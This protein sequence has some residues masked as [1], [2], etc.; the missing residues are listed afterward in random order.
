MTL[1]YTGKVK[2]TRH[3]PVKHSFEYSVYTYG[4]ELETISKTAEKLPFFG[5]NCFNIS[6]LHN[7]DYLYPNQKDI[8]SKLLKL[9]KKKNIDT[10]PI[11]SVTLVTS[12]RFFHYAFNPV[13]FYYCMDRTGSP[14]AIVAEVNN[15]F[16]EKHIYILDKLM[17]GKGKFIA[18]A[19]AR[20]TFHVSP[21]NNM[22]GEYEFFFGDLK[23]ELNIHINLRRDDKIILHT[24]ITGKPVR[25]SPMKHLGVLLKFPLTTFVTFPRISWEAAKLYFI[26]KL[27]IH[28]KPYPKDSMTIIKTGPG[29]MEKLCRKILFTLFQKI[30]IGCLT[31]I[32]PNEDH[33]AFGDLNSEIQV[34][35]KINEY[36]FYPKVI[37][38]GDIGFGDAYV[39]NL[40]ECKDLTQL[41][42]LFVENDNLNDGNLIYSI[43]SRFFLKLKHQK[44]KN[45]LSQSKRNIESHYDLG[46]S[47]YKLFLDKT[48]TY[49][50]GIFRS[51]TESLEQSQ[52]NKIDN[53]ID[54]LELSPNDSLLEIGCGW[55]SFLKNSVE[56]TRCTATGITLSNEQYDYCQNI[57][58]KLGL[59]KQ[60]NILIKDYRKMEGKFDKIVSIEMIEAVGHEYLADFFKKCE[61]L[62]KSGG[63]LAIQVI[64]IADEKY[65]HY[66]N[67]C[68]WIQKRIFPGG[69]LPS[70]NLLK[71]TISKHTNLVIKDLQSLGFDYATTL[72]YW[73]ENFLKKRDDLLHLG[74]DQAFQRKWL[75]YFHY[76]EAGFLE[77]VI[78]NYQ[79]LIEKPSLGKSNEN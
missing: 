63:K 14:V 73:R 36:S 11:Q 62:L 21:F 33:F 57:R 77:Q 72:A 23:K 34:V 69:H 79:I 39:D 65:E 47:F 75:Y 15:T 66:K 59:E 35:L 4:I 25:L 16:G 56:K 5:M 38:H 18:R 45:T 19:T 40:W 67:S 43:L 61:S 74:Y 51:E 8:K 24:Q 68:D 28:Q 31:V 13:S 49:S 70:V 2:H 46:N 20:K 12:A 53:L 52:Y 27:T 78:D 7:K 64:T 37:F 29:T 22:D 6:A 9:L 32:D 71:N 76:C 54:K 17:P 41:L 42:T 60:M 48:M 30:K 10:T 55:G 44:N 58:E 50:A 26:K 1:I 3:T